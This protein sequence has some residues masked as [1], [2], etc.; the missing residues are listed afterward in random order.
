LLEEAGWNLGADGVRVRGETRLAFECV[1]QDDAIHRKIAEGVRDCLRAVG[2]DL[3]LRPVLT[4]QGFYR[5]CEAGPASFI[6]KW[7]WQ[8]TV[9]AAIGFT[10]SWGIASPNWQ[11][12]SVPALDDAYHGWLR[13]ETPDEL[14]AAASRAQQIAADELPDIPLLV[15]HD[16]WVCRR[17]VQRW[18]P[19]QAILYPFYHRTTIGS[20]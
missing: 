13:A 18:E 11:Y 17:E 2:I 14:Q 20:A 12:A 15:P 19:A 8:D 3:Q 16:V 7:L 9:D 10:A 4:F 6:N 1:I 5:A